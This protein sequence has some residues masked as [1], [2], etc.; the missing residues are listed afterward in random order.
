MNILTKAGGAIV[1]GAGLF[2]SGFYIGSSS[3][4]EKFS[5]HP[6]IAIYKVLAKSD[7]NHNFALE[8]NEVLHAFDV[9]G[10]G[11]LD[12]E[13]RMKAREMSDLFDKAAKGMFDTSINLNRASKGQQWWGK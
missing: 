13:E 9:N 5:Q 3:E 6:S 7:K 1:A 12:A 2:T 10:D 11:K 4:K 8:G